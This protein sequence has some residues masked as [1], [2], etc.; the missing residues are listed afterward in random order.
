MNALDRWLIRTFARLRRWLARLIDSPLPPTP[1][2]ITITYSRERPTMPVLETYK[3]TVS[4]TVDPAIVAK[5]EVTVI[6]TP[7]GATDPQ[8]SFVVVA[9]TGTE[10]DLP[11]GATAKVF[12]TD[13]T[14]D[15]TAS[16]PGPV[17]TVIVGPATPGAVTLEHVGE[18]PAA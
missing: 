7:H 16:K 3:L 14:A 13:Y 6:V 11:P 8:P 1:G 9:A 15:G 2:P 18:K 12:Q 4:P 17:T 10:I 5:S